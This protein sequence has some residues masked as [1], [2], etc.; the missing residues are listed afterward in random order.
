MT[1]IE[2]KMAFLGLFLVVA[3]ILLFKVGFVLLPFAL[4]FVLAHF[5][6]PLVT[7]F[8]KCKM[9]RS[10]AV[11]VIILLFFLFMAGFVMGVVPFLYHQSMEMVSQVPSYIEVCRN[12]VYPR[13][14][15]LLNKAGMGVAFDFDEIFD[16]TQIIGFAK[17]FSA[18]IFSSTASVINVLSLIF[19]MPILIFYLLRDWN[20]M[21]KAVQ[22]YLSKEAWGGFSRVLGE[23]DGAL[24][25]YVRGQ[26]TVCVLMALVYAVLLGFTGLNFGVLIGVLTG[27]FSF[28]PYIGAL[29]GFVVA[30]LM[31]LFQWGFSFFEVS[32]VI[33]AFMVGQVI[34]SNFLTPNLI[35]QR[36]GLHPLWIIFGIFV[37]GSLFGLFGVI[38]ATPLSAVFGVLLKNLAQEY[39]KRF[40]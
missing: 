33:A 6:H 2:S 5:L 37:F 39:K 24:S 3:M 17:N 29:T 25:G 15:E 12:E 7:Y 13:Y 14:V 9:P 34:E 8:V 21:V 10:L 19:I 26:I 30:V 27:F 23:V 1:K 16:A 20:L 28:I 18:G 35:G 31:A 11:A 36:V 38:F 40:I 4:S 32:L 22:G